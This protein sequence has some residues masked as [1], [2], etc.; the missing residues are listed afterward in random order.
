MKID[1]IS[2]LS[3]LETWQL[4]AISI[5]ID[6]IVL[7]AIDDK[8]ENTILRTITELYDVFRPKVTN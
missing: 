1:W 4:Q 8:D 7:G 5:L 2:E 3:K 6:L